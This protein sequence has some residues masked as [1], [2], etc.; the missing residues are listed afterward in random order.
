MTAKKSKKSNHQILERISSKL[1][2]DS[3]P[4]VDD[5]LCATRFI[6]SILS[7]VSKYGHFAPF[8]FLLES[9]WKYP[10]KIFVAAFRFRQICGCIRSHVW[11]SALPTIAPTASLWKRFSFHADPSFSDFQFWFYLNRYDDRFSFRFFLFFCQET[12]TYPPRVSQN[13]SKRNLFVV[14][15]KVAIIRNIHTNWYLF[16]SWTI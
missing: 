16:V 13:R 15:Y 11:S 7:N 2:L 3:E 9:R 4:R 14:N 8:E 10:W 6:D 5:N 12:I 1:W